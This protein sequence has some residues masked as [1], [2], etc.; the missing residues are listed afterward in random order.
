MKKKILSV[1]LAAALTCSMV[2]GC[3]S[4]KETAKDDK[5]ATAYVQGFLYS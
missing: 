1:I 5:A 4:S 2:V 3:S